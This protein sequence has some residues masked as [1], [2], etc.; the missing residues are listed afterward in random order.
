MVRRFRILSW[1]LLILLFFGCGGGDDASGPG[2]RFIARLDGTQQ[3]PSVGTTATG[4]GSFVLNAAKTELT[5][6]ITVSGLSGP[7]AAARFLNAPAGKPGTSVRTFT[8]DFDDNTASGVWKNTDGEPFSP[9]LVKELEEGRIYINVN[10]A[11]NPTGEI[12]GQVNPIPTGASLRPR[13]T[14]PRRSPR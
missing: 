2:T 6:R 11:Q 1:L 9:P 7:L 8:A 13:W 4:T 10:S 3:T 14:G 12:R 5:F